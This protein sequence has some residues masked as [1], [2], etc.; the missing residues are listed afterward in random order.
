MNWTK[1]QRG[2]IGYSDCA[3]PEIGGDERETPVTFGDHGLFED[4]H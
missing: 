3:D 2:M 1:P 4:M